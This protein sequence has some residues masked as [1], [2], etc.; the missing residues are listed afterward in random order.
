[1]VYV[2]K[3]ISLDNLKAKISEAIPSITENI[4][5]Y[6]VRILVMLEDKWKLKL[7]NFFY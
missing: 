5:P 2:T 4:W 1:M 3:L 7:E 6:A